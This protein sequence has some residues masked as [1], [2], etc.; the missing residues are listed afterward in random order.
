MGIAIASGAA[1]AAAILGGQD[2]RAFQQRLARSLARPM[3]VAGIFRSLAESPAA[4]RPLV[5][6][7]R[8]A[9]ILV[10][11]VARLTRISTMAVD[12]AAH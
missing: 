2:A 6:I 12:D 7:A 3:G 5:A 8:A 1:A 9:P 10:A 11:A 4:A